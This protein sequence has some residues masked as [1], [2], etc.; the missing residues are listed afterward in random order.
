MRTDN[1]LLRVAGQRRETLTEWVICIVLGAAL[2]GIL[3]AFI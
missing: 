3:A 2:G 1:N